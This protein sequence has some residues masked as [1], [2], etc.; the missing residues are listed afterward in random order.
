MAAF[1][2]TT[3]PTSRWYVA[4]QVVIIQNLSEAL[5][6]SLLHSTSFALEKQF[7]DLTFDSFFISK[8]TLVAIFYE[9]RAH[10]S[11]KNVVEQGIIMENLQ[12][13][14][15]LFGRTSPFS[16]QKNTLKMLKSWTFYL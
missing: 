6:S 9:T 15:R 5:Q 3:A 11:I 14:F 13:H 10:T 7:K 16:T 8:K 1:S 2:E 4:E 12:E